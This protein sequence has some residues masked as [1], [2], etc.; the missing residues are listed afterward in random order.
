MAMI[1]LSIR[2]LL[3]ITVLMFA[4]LLVVIAY[5]MLKRGLE[6]SRNKKKMKYIETKQKEWYSYLIEDREP[7]STLI[8]NNESEV[9]AVEEI[10]S[11]YLYNISDSEIL[12]KIKLFS[13]NYFKE[14]Y[15]SRIRS[16][17][18]STRMN[19]LYHIFDFQMDE[20][21]EECEQLEIKKLTLQEQVQLLKIYSICHKE[22]FIT[23][24]LQ[25]PTTLTEYEYKKVLYRLDPTVLEQ[26]IVR[27]DDLPLECQYSLI[28]ILGVKREPQY[29]SFLESC[30][31]NDDAEI[32]IRTL[33]AIFEIGIITDLDKYLPFIT[34]QIWEERLMMAKLLGALPISITSSYLQEL[35]EDE[36]WW[37]RTQ[38]AKSIGRNKD[39][40]I[41]LQSYI[42]S[43]ND[44]YAIEMANQVLG[45]ES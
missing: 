5:L 7:S 38:A 14:Y 40:K 15:R 29:L 27:M 43:S 21:V 12:A 17:R 11:S 44:R 20:L 19:A 23:K 45:K 36:N 18:W 31:H 9:K 2:I 24:L 30:L 16:H 22:V 34:S 37:V 25:C 33:K 8:P 32:R 3:T 39:G 10:F 26:L 41:V 42:N 6:V 35:L 1:E 28:D 4:L 13:N